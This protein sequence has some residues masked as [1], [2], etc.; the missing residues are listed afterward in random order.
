MLST[1]NTAPSF[2]LSLFLFWSIIEPA[3]AN[4]LL[5]EDVT[6]ISP[7]RNSPL[8]HAYL[9][10]NDGIITEVSTSKLR[11]EVIEGKQPSV[12]V[13]GRGRY[14]IPG[15]IDSHVHLAKVPSMTWRHKQQHPD[16]ERSYLKQQPRSYL[17]FGYTSLIDL[18]VFSPE[19][20]ETFT[21]QT[22]HPE[23]FTC[24][25]HLDIAN[26]HGMMEEDVKTRLLNNPNFLYDH[27]QKQHLNGEYDLSQHTAKATVKRIKDDGGVCI[28]TY[29]E[30]G[31]GG[32]EMV[33]FDIPSPQIIKDVAVEGKKQGI[34]TLL[35]ANSWTSQRVALLADVDIIAHGMFHWDEYRHEVE[36]PA[37]IRATLKEIASRGMGYQP[38]LHVLDAQRSM[39]DA[40]YLNN[41]SL[42]KVYP[43]K[44]LGWYRSDEGQWFKSR[45]RKYLPRHLHELDDEAM[46]EHFS[47]YYQHNVKVLEV[48][49]E[50]DANLLFA[51]DTIIGQS[52]ANAPGLSGY[53]EMQAW[54]SA[55]VS[56]R[57]ILQA[58]TIN[59]AKAFNLEASIGSIEVGKKANLLLL[60]KNP[61]KTV[62]AYNSIEWI[63]I[64]GQAVARQTLAA[65]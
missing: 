62:E 1:H 34:P 15:L 20:I 24:S 40:N 56:L 42:E 49:A 12:R 13:D 22:L 7:E 9:R 58:A 16:L 64:N 29:Y 27:Y 60:T 31:Y 10:V 46:H 44:L 57:K 26:G 59:N 11:P 8:N 21:A 3:G 30:N 54:N 2:F 61:L 18:N 17:Y 65:D 37:P 52:Y 38:T 51:T 47:K 4:E 48:L 32:S 55:G 39:F 36:V 41:S 45:I 63:F 6:L 43:K 35:H 33:D 14:L 5:I 28:K 19:A 50:Y 23:V 25:K 53:I